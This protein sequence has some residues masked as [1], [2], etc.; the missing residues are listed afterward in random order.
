MFSKRSSFA[1]S[2]GNK[3][4][5]RDLR[6]KERLIE[7][8]L[9]EPT[10]DL[11]KLRELALSEGGL[12]SGTSIHCIC[13]PIRGGGCGLLR[14]VPDIEFTSYGW[15]HSLWCLRLFY[16]DAN[17]QRAW[18][19]LVGL[20]QFE[21]ARTT[22]QT[23]SSIRTAG[24]T[25]SAPVDL[26]TSSSSLPLSTEHTPSTDGTV[27]FIIETSSLPDLDTRDQ[28]KQT[29]SSTDY[30]LLVESLDV[31]QIERDV[32]RCTWHLL[33]GSQR[34]RRDQIARKDKSKKVA[35]LL[36]KKQRR[37]ANLINLVLVESYPKTSINGSIGGRLRYYQGYHDVACIFMHALG[38]AGTNLP[39]VAGRNPSDTSSS[40]MDP[41]GL[42]LAS[43]VLALVSTSHLKDFCQDDFLRLTSSLRLTLYPLLHKLDPLV[44]N[45]LRDVDMEPFFCLSWILTWF[46]HSVR[47]TNLCKRLFDAFLSSH[48]LFVLYVALAMML[49]PFNRKC[50][51]ETDCDFAA[52]HHTLTNLPQHSCRVGYTTMAEQT[53][54]PSGGDDDVERDQIEK[55]SDHP[56]LDDDFSAS[57]DMASIATSGKIGNS[58]AIANMSEHTDEEHNTCQVPF[59][60]LLEM[61]VGYMA[62]YP[63]RSV[64]D[65][66]KRYYGPEH[67]LISEMTK[68]TKDEDGAN[69]T[70]SVLL[71]EAPVCCLR[72]ETTADWVLKQRLRQEMGL[73]GTNRKDRRRKNHPSVHHEVDVA[74]ETPLIAREKSNDNNK[75]GPD[76]TYLKRNSRNHAVIAAG[77]G[78]GPEALAILR[79]KRRRYATAVSFGFVAMSI[80]LGAQYWYGK[81]TST[82]K[83]VFVNMLFHPETRRTNTTILST[84]ARSSSDLLGTAYH[85]LMACTLQ[86]TKLQ[87]TERPLVS[88]EARSSEEDQVLESGASASASQTSM[89]SKEERDVVS[90]PRNLPGISDP[91][92]KVC[93][94]SDHVTGITISSALQLFGIE[95]MDELRGLEE[96]SSEI[97]DEEPQTDPST[98][99]PN[100]GPNKRSR[101]SA[102]SMI[103]TRQNLH[104]DRS[105][106]ESN[107]KALGERSS[108][109]DLEA[110]Q[111]AFEE[112]SMVQSTTAL[113]K[114]PQGQSS[115][116][117]DITS[118]IVRNKNNIRMLKLGLVATMS[119]RIVT[120]IFA[121]ATLPF[122]W[123]L[124]RETI[125]SNLRKLLH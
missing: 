4:G 16:V 43:Q 60:T 52:L 57:T 81:S 44:H 93:A 91:A 117:G 120:R 75:D 20:Q 51:L 48:P 64:G 58:S 125:W 87:R 68:N 10:V 95:M 96:E 24:T 106:I 122:E 26:Q 40:A 62:R 109:G 90:C 45:H 65:L 39:T 110:P 23:S 30:G 8:V 119:D 55:D 85:F 6:E 105:E 98:S 63:P 107:A 35:A 19:K 73:S 82:R 94:S 27:N 71:E 50:I 99:R 76:Y 1:P 36:K 46:S 83:A 32:A 111:R 115:Q 86:K 97:D 104:R 37:L 103:S 101:A 34:S 100:K 7:L 49:H 84:S 5:F 74:L 28:L 12:V 121:M 22:T 113:S 56:V 61:A 31:E 123:L 21:K 38:G 2:K 89:V 17:R 69:T 54:H 53:G 77:F 92:E 70:D 79:R 67:D 15:C 80:G 29:S 112:A 25:T 66:A 33:T 88:T 13:L 11:W 72:S 47:D 3:T 18:P 124:R 59:E 42:Q 114:E 14:L 108:T 102:E 9:L 118:S 116:T 41:L 78:P